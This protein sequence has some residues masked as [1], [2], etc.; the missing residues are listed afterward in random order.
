MNFG[1]KPGCNLFDRVHP[2][3]ANR[4]KGF[5]D[6]NCPYSDF[7]KMATLINLPKSKE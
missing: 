3:N 1:K 7:G 5:P 4:L 6:K 2:L